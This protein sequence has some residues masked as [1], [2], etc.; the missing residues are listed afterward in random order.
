[1]GWF[2][3][4]WKGTATEDYLL[5]AMRGVVDGCELIRLLKG[6]ARN[7]DLRF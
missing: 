6:L 5:G 2:E 7:H 1:M 4:A 3:S